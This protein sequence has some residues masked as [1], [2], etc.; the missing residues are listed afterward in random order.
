MPKIHW[1]PPIYTLNISTNLERLIS[2]V[3]LFGLLT[4]YRPC[5]YDLCS[6]QA[7]PSGLLLFINLAYMAHQSK[8]CV[9]AP[10][11]TDPLQKSKKNHGTGCWEMYLL[12]EISRISIC[13]NMWALA[14]REWW[15]SLWFVEDIWGRHSDAVS[16][17]QTARISWFPHTPT[18]HPDHSPISPLLLGTGAPHS[19]FLDIFL[20]WI[21]V[22]TTAGFPF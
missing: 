21:S 13:A 1:T 11:S 18:S 12:I 20:S 19:G 9:K 2:V 4:I 16:D 3:L 14:A 10:Q 17:S 6:A 8:L 7:R 15:R 5:K 22:Q